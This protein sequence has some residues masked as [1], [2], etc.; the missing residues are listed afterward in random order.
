MIMPNEFTIRWIGQGGY[1]LRCNGSTLLV[2][3]YFS[4]LAG[5][6]RLVPPPWD[7]KDTKTDFFLVTHDHADHLDV[8]MIREMNCEGVRFLCPESCKTALRA[9]DKGIA[10]EQITTMY[11]GG[12]LDCGDFVLEALYANHTP[13]SLGFV[14]ACNGLRLYITGDT[15]YDEDVGA[16]ARADVVCCCINGRWGNM[17]AAEAVE[18]ALRSGARLAIPNHYG[19]F[20]ENTADPADFTRAAEARGIKTYVMEQDEEVDLAGLAE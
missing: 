11:R 7:M 14:V 2:D 12:F 8:D 3:P 19:M 13:D 9:L 16:N 5:H 17:D 4:N 1:A 18:V 10:E 15:L 20:A 6:Q